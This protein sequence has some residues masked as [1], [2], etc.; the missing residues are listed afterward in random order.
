MTQAAAGVACAKVIL[1]IRLRS[2]D[3]MIK[4]RGHSVEIIIISEKHAI[5]SQL[6]RGIISAENAK[7]R[8]RGLG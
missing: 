6:L 7:L 1:N 8:Q 4:G 3:E 2:G 5:G